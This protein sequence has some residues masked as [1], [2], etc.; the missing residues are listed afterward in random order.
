[1]TG[2]P[3]DSNPNI[4]RLAEEKLRSNE[5]ANL[6]TL[7]PEET[8]TLLHELRVHQIELE[9]QNAELRRLQKDLD[10]SQ[11]RY[12]FLYDLAPVG[13]LTISEQGLIQEANLAAATILGAAKD[14]LLRKPITQFILRED[15]TVYYMQRK[16]VLEVNDV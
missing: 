9:M 3:T 13:Y 6:E 5:A 16:R 2:A 14:A 8:Q 7:S 11:H 1:M 12:F 4:R 15:Q 10:I